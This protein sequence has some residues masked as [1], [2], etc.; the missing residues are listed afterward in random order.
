MKKQMKFASLSASI[1]VSLF[2]A[3]ATVYQAEPAKSNSN[4]VV[5]GRNPS[6][7][8][9]CKETPECL[10]VVFEASKDESGI[11]PTGNALALSQKARQWYLENRGKAY[12][13]AREAFLKKRMEKMRSLFYIQSNDKGLKW[14]TPTKISPIYSNDSCQADIAIEKNGALDVVWADTPY[15]DP[16][17]D[18][19]LLVPNIYFTRSIDDGITWSKPVAIAHAQISSQ[20]TIAIG[21]DNMIHVVW[22]STDIFYSCS[23]NGGKQWG[24]AVSI[25]EPAPGSA[26]EP[27]ISVDSAGVIQVAWVDTA[28]GEGSPNIYYV[29][30]EQGMWTEPKNV[31][32]SCGTISAHPRIASS[33]FL[34]WSGDGQFSFG[35][36]G[37]RKTKTVDIRF[38]TTCDHYE[39]DNYHSKLSGHYPGSEGAHCF[40][41]IINISRPNDVASEPAIAESPPH[42]LAVVW[43]DSVVGAERADIYL[44]ASTNGGDHFSPPINLSNY[45]RGRCQHPD[46]AIIGKK[47]CAIWEELEDGKSVLKTK[48]V[49]IAADAPE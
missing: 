21:P 8:A 48:L 46:V 15:R 49:D 16:V 39:R 36:N 3:I 14:T 40:S 24:K 32:N 37:P 42:N 12:N 5:E 44:R 17:G 29:R 23:N 26:R 35:P 43:T 10:H 22:C 19:G 30:K 4:F 11:A 31:S 6:I 13:D 9:D 28:S 2:L 7:V 34:V 45:S 20:P 18:D 33:F 25:S 27:T 1:A 38:A 41:S 47:D